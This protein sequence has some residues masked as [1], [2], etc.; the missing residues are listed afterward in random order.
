MDVV[1]A[2]HLALGQPAQSLV[3]LLIRVQQPRQPAIGLMDFLR[4]GFLG[5]SQFFVVV[6]GASIQLPFDLS[7]IR[8]LN[9]RPQA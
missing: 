5:Q 2:F 6:H 9:S 3:L 1:E 7:A 8:G 4:R